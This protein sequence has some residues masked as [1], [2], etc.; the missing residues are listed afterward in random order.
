MRVPVKLKVQMDLYLLLILLLL[1]AA[2]AAVARLL[3]Q[4]LLLEVMAE[5]GAVVEVR[6]LVLSLREPEVAELLVKD[7]LGAMETLQSPLLVAVAVQ[8]RLVVMA[9]AEQ[10]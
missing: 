9:V 8:A 5:A 10:Q 3:E 1:R 6:Y 2:A 4:R 7:S